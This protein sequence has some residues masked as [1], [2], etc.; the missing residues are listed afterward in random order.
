MTLAYDEQLGLPTR[1]TNI[2]DQKIDSLSVENYEMI[3]A[4]FQV[5]NKFCKTRFF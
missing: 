4:A 2:K 1:K 3:I 5:T